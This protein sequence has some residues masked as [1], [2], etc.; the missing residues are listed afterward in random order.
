MSISFKIDSAPP[1]EY[2]EPIND[3]LD[4]LNYSF[5]YRIMTA[6]NL[7]I[8]MTAFKTN[9][10]YSMLDHNNLIKKEI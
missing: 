8:I 1:R 2:L 5:R 9:N 3:F 6:Q 4:L 7:E 10:L